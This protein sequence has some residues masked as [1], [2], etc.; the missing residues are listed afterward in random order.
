MPLPAAADA[1]S[2]RHQLEFPRRSNQYVQI[3]SSFPASGEK[4]EIEIPVWT[5]G[6]YMVRD[7]SAQVE[8]LAATGGSGR[9]LDARKTAKNRWSIDTSGET[10]F[11]VRYD[12]W[13]GVLNVANSWVDASGALLNGAGLF[14]YTGESRGMVQHVN[15]EMPAEWPGIHSSMASGGTRN[16][17][18]AQDYDELVDSPIIAGSTE[19]YDFEVDDQGYSL[20]FEGSNDF[21]DGEQSGNDLARLVEA[22]QK[23]WGVNPFDRKYLFINLFKGPFGGLEHD[24]ST[25]L[26][27]S[28]LA[29]RLRKDYIKWLGLV[30]HEFFHAWN[31]RRLRPV[32]LVDYDYSR[33]MYTRELWLAE[34]ITSYYDNLLL[35]RAGLIQV[36]EYLEL[37]ASDIR[38]FETTPG[39]EIRS[40]ELASFDTWIKHYKQDENS[41]NSTV[42]YYRKG[43]LIGF[44]TDMEVRRATDG[45]AN[46]DTVMRTLYERH[47]LPEH[48]GYPPGAFEKVVGQIAGP[49]VQKRVAAMLRTT[50]DPDTNEALEW[51]GLTL[52][53]SPG[54]A[55][56]SATGILAP[57]GLGVIWG[58]LGSQLMVEQVVRGLAGAEAGLLPG[59]ELLA[60][61]GHRVTALDYAGVIQRLQPGEN[62]EL[63]IARHGRLLTLMAEVQAAIPEIY[64]I[65]PDLKIRNRQKKRMEQWLGLDLIFTKN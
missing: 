54:V 63:T 12:V 48:N 10:S 38:D 50:G 33:E 53:R 57:A 13:A 5:P 41:V 39:R 34:G 29:M 43:A 25:V 18:I 47:A 60:I 17:F 4:T 20:V 37:L 2:V 58:E 32:E 52:N 59:D 65:A 14:M 11:S 28:P 40:A 45:K 16:K 19:S 42:S 3:S 30:S 51:Y 7:Y 44:V 21:W 55:A 8:N 62:V 61:A 46:L 1:E 22:H 26:M 31:I 64:H 15:V 36:T 56:A 24:N 35:L 9:V 6:S 49:E 27:I 23:F